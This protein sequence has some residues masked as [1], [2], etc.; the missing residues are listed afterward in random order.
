MTGE[1]NRIRH[2]WE[3]RTGEQAL[4]GAVTTAGG[5]ILIDVK[6]KLIAV[7]SKLLVY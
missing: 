4:A 3:S 1:K 6:I 7:G 5:K 2:G